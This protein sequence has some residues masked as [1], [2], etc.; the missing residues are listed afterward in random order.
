LYSLKNEATLRN[1][2]PILLV[3]GSQ[4]ENAVCRSLRKL[5][6]KF[7]RIEMSPNICSAS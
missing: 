7:K 1:T 2:G 5:E 4:V 6:L 3:H